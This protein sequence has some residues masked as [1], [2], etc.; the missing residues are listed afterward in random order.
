MESLKDGMQLS[1]KGH[2]LIRD[3]ATG[4]ILLDKSILLTKLRTNK[5]ETK[6]DE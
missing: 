4:E 5:L 3:P 1:F 2:V 6:S